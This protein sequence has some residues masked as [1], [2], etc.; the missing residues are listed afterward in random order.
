KDI[1]WFHCV[2]W[3]CMLRSAGLALPK[4]VFA[5]GFITAGDGRKMSKTLGNVVDPHAMCNRYPVDTFRW[6][7][8]REAAFGSDL[9][10]SECSLMAMHNAELCDTLGNLV[11]RTVSLCDKYNAG[12]VPAPLLEGPAAVW[13]GPFDV[14][15]LR[16]ELAAAFADCAVQQACIL[17]MAAL[18]DTNKFL[19]EAEPWKMGEQRAAERLEV[20]R[21]SMEAVYVLAH[22]LAPVIPMAGTAVFHKLGQGPVPIPTLRTDY[23]NL[24]AGTRVAVGRILFK[25]MEAPEAAAAAAD[26]AA[27]GGGEKGNSKGKGKGGGAENGAARKG[28][29]GGAAEDSR[30][31]TDPSRL[32]IRVGVIMR[33]WPHPE[34]EKLFCEE[35]DIGETAPRLIASGLRAFYSTEDLQERR[36]LVLANLKARPMAG[37]KSEGMVLCASDA[38]HTTVAFIDPPAAA[39]IGTRIVFP[40]YVGEPAPAVQITKKKTLEKVMPRLRT[41]AAGVP[42]CDGTPFVAGEAG[43]CASPLPDAVVS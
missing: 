13:A 36:V 28:G 32:D 20:V 23:R 10:F 37:F 26:V 11:H 38:A 31:E 25:K 6:Y 29:G 24:A 41:D 34:S 9:A 14:E 21:T 19:T 7:M 5:H 17:T 42:G 33:A 27:A 12:T 16:S 3:P 8:M 1:I 43:A 30:D 39:A 22:F 35:I 40:G 4:R 18:R 15:K 2:I